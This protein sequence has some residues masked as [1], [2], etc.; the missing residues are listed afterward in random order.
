MWLGTQPLWGWRVLWGRPRV[1]LRAAVQPWAL[2]RNP[3]GIGGCWYGGQGRD[4][5]GS[6]RAVTA[7]ISQ[8]G[9]RAERGAFDE[10]G[11][12]DG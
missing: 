4:G 6:G 8:T 2:R 12:D 7:G 11:G 3:V 9:P 1:G 5:F 10:C